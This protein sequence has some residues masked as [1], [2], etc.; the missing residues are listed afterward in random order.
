MKVLYD[1]IGFAQNIG[2]VSRYLC[3]IISCMPNDIKFE[4]ALKQSDNV[5]LLNKRIIKNVDS[6]KITAD[7]YVPFKFPLKKKVFG[8]LQRFFPSFPSANN[9]NKQYSIDRINSGDFDLLH[10]TRFNDYFLPYIGKKPFVFTIH[11]LNHE[12]FNY[13]SFEQRSKK[14][15]SKN[16]A[17]II[18]ISENTKN[19]LMRIYGISDDK[20]TVIHHGGPELIMF[21]K[22]PIIDSPYFLYVGKRH[23]YKNFIQTLNDVS[24]FIKKHPNVK[25]V[26]TGTPFTH[27]ERHIINDLRMQ[28][29]IIQLFVTD[30][31]LANL[32]SNAL[33]FIYPSLYEGFGL[34]ILEAYTYKCPVLL[35]NKSCF[36]EI[37]GN[38]AIYFDSQPNES[39]LPKKLFELYD[40]S[41]EQRLRLIELGTE[42]LKLYNWKKAAQQTANI[43]RNIIQK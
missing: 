31:Q 32:Y 40:M 26:C 33:A 34:P 38:A 24:I 7:S 25:F 5:Y 36:P 3:E 21:E 8:A 22:K 1:Y 17:H 19:D 18:A 37:A 11:D 30:S 4:I 20:I 39:N 2:G 6:P 15:L 27:F 9:I 23:G 29:N 41:M 35:N 12:I 43:Y 10:H 13:N 28:K 42:R 14:I 16:A